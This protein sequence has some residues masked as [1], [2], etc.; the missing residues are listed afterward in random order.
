MLTS[1]DAPLRRDIRLLG[2]VLGRVLVEQSGQDL[3]EDEERIRALAREAR[4]GRGQE[5]LRQAVRG[6]TLD[7]QT[8]VLRAF[9]VYFQ[10]ANIAEQ[11]HR[12]R[13]RRQYEHA[14]RESLAEALALLEARGVGDEELARAAASISLEL[15]LTAHPTEAARRTVLAAHARVN[16]LLDAHDAGLVPQVE[17]EERLA[18]E[19]TMLWQ[20]DEVRE[21]RPRVA[22]E[23]RSG[24][25]FFEESLLDAAQRL[26][27]AFRRHFP[28][29]PAPLHFGSWIGGDQDGNPAAGPDTIEVAL[30]R[31]RTLV[32][33]R[34]R[35][36]VRALAMT[37]G[38][39]ASLAGA[40][41]E[42]TK[43][44]VRDEHELPHYAAHLGAQNE[45]EP[46]R[47]KLSFVWW[48]LGNDGYRSVAELAADLDEIDRSLRAHRG[49]RL[50]D[51]RL[52]ALRLRVELFGFHLAKLDV[53]VHAHDLADPDERLRETFAAIK[54]ARTRHGSAALDTVIVSGTTSP[55]DVLRVLDLA[56]EPLSVVPL[57]E[58]IDDLGAAAGVVDALLDDERFAPDGRIEVMVGYS[59]SGKDGGYLAA[60]WAIWRAQEELAAVAERRGV[61][62]TIFHGRGGSAGRGGGPTHAAIL[63]QPPGHPPGRLKIT[64]QGETISFKYGLR[65]LA[66]RN[67]E[68]AL[69]ATLL[70]ALPEFMHATPSVEARRTMDA[71]AQRGLRAY[72]ELVW[73]DPAFVDFFRAFTP[74]DELALLQIGSRPAQRSAGG[75]FLGSLRAIPWVFAWTQN[76]C[77]LPSWYGCGTALAPLVDDAGVELL[78]DL[79][80][81]W[82]FF[83]SLIE[84]LEMTLAKSRLEI[85]EGY[86]EL[87]PLGP[88]ADRIWQRIRQEHG[89]AVQAVLAIVEADQLLD[90]HPVL[91]RSIRLRNP[92]VDPMNAIQVE[93]LRRYR[94]AAD[95]GR[96]QVRRP[97]VRSI[98][99]IAAALRN[100]G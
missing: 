23:I 28:D 83:R 45:G 84:N 54:R 81:D 69:A 95:E 58:T 52:A 11:H 68:A 55:Q 74:I 61:E 57:F 38:L 32:L 31:A 91:Q 92:Y 42:L 19:V 66:Y 76:R 96:A 65:E 8:N 47:R 93:L 86:L 2:D 87:V 14:P 72:R 98:A 6:L 79:Y 75:D 33:D 3:L 80:R 88:D 78:R 36:E 59:D 63:A 73:D 82:A 13:R 48:R 43:S 41:R 53:R 21:Q 46:Y 10:L 4:R 89:A 22:D 30:E 1:A 51:G 18:E 5:P 56:N 35:T 34:L 24:L 44:I 12:L 7:R 99:G 15:V 37:L 49:A 64:E 50:A 60:Q 9:A 94:A 29:A 97:L 85:A 67:L 25:W 70:S 90:R 39:S 27:A 20:T 100:T 40:A 17:I 77:L 62:L 26:V 16:E 71:L